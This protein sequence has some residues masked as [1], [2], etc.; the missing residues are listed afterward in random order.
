MGF[1]LVDRI[2]KGA[3]PSDLPIEHPT[4]FELVINL[5]TAKA[6]GLAVRATLLTSADKVIERIRFL[7]RCMSPFMAPS[8][9]S[10]RIND[11]LNVTQS[12][13]WAAARR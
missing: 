10:Q 9:P 13:P 12:R 6:V 3:K 8:S 11:G 2:L 5:K 1:G 7:P 4:R